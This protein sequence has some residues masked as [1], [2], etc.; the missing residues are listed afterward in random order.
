MGD[1]TA[2]KILAIVMKISEFYYKVHIKYPYPLYPGFHLLYEKI[3]PEA[4]NMLPF[5]APT[6]GKTTINRHI[7]QAVFVWENNIA[8]ILILPAQ[9]IAVIHQIGMKVHLQP[10]W[11]TINLPEVNP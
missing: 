8:P 10:A 7:V 1:N 2:V 9:R 6:M 3:V 11:P 5:P 4:E